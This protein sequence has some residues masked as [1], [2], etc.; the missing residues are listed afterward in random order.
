MNR[1]ISDSRRGH[2]QQRG[3]GWVF[4]LRGEARSEVKRA[5]RG[6][7]LDAGPDGAKLPF[8]SSAERRG[9]TLCRGAALGPRPRG[10]P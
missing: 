9:E 8:L 4:P 7:V 5:N 10:P 1:S 2:R 6:H 3:K